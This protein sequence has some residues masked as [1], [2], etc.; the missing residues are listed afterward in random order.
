MGCA[1]AHAILAQAWLGQLLQLVIACGTGRLLPFWLHHPL[2]VGTE[3]LKTL[4]DV[5]AWVR[6]VLTRNDSIVVR[7]KTAVYYKRGLIL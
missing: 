7:P 3:G 2:S 4:C 5:S 6:W 1:L